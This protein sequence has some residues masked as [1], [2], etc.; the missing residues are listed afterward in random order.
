MGSCNMRAKLLALPFLVAAMASAASPLFRVLRDDTSDVILCKAEGVKSCRKIEVN[1]EALEDDRI[2]VGEYEYVKKHNIDKGD[3]R[4]Y[5]Y[6]LA[7]GSVDHRWD[8]VFMVFKE[9]DK[10]NGRFLGPN[11][12]TLSINNCMRDGCNVLIRT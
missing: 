10:V 1:Y 3:H 11:G 2:R 7:S 8:G 5:G 6:E 9:G 4:L 12:D